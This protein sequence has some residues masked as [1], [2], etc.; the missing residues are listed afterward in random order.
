MLKSIKSNDNILISTSILN[1]S[2]D[3]E[4]INEIDKTST[5]Y[6]HLDIMDGKFV[7][8]KCEYINK[9]DFNKKV[10]I[11]LMVE[12]VVGYVHK[13]KDYKPEFITF[14]YES[15][16]TKIWDLIKYISNYSKVGIAIN[17]STDVDTLIPYLDDID[18]VLVMSVKAGMGG[19]KFIDISDKINKLITLRKENNYAFQIEVDGGI[20]ID[21][22]NKCK[23]ADIL[24]V[25]SYITNSDNY[26]RQILNIK[27][28]LKK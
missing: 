23:N 14:H 9:I 18:L 27:N 1:I 25:G 12:D 24:V 4:K 13:Y 28:I 26:E 17:P 20:N 5:D 3:I 10:D 21:T 6:I 15:N 11:H 8:N 16:E 7:A 22:V 19:Q 2:N